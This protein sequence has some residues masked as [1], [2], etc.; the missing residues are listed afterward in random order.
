MNSTTPPIILTIDDEKNIRDSFRYF[1]EDNGYHVLEAANGRIGLE[2]FQ[3]EH[4]DLVMVDLK[5]P[6]VDGLEVLATITSIAPDTPII[7]I[8][9]TG[10]LGDVV[11]ALHLGAW[12]YLL[13]PVHDLDILLHAVKK[14]LERAH[15]LKENRAYREHL[16]EMVQLRTQQLE[17]ANSEL[18][19]TRMEII[20]RLGKAAEYKDNETGRHVIRVA[21]YSALLAQE[22]GLDAKT[23]DMIR[24][25]SPM[26][27]LG[28]IGIP[29]YIL[30]K[31]GILDEEEWEIMFR[32]CQ[33]G[34]TMLGP[35]PQEDLI[36]YQH[37]TSIGEDILGGSS[38]QL[39]ETA[40][41]IAGYHHEHWDG[42]GY[43]HRLKGEEIP[44]EA[45]IVAVADVYDALSSKRAY[46]EPFSETKCLQILQELS[47]TILD[48][49]VTAV[50]F[51]NKDKI[52]AIK[53]NWH[54]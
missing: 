31:P 45:R 22:L 36:L 28:K 52:M 27:D 1:L 29:D 33:I 49:N 48:P 37:H 25:C 40:A 26:H 23:V 7:I 51:K 46:K 53:E 35:L 3:R 47:G 9:G 14:A 8:S 30:L 17:A 16:E 11:S 18:Q 43:P 12:D 21:L 4:P 5:M 34:S 54:D 44:I 13:K 6:E 42:T 39:L 2:I 20:R 38:S 32:H 19:K 41:R 10:V 50:F 15:L 24:Q